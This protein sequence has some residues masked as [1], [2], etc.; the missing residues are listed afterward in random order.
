[1][2]GRRLWTAICVLIIVGM[3][4]EVLM[5]TSM[6]FQFD[7]SWM[8][9]RTSMMTLMLCGMLLC[10]VLFAS[11]YF[12]KNISKNNFFFMCM[13][14]LEYLL[15]LNEF[16][17]M[18]TLEAHP[19]YDIAEL[20]YLL[21]NMILPLMVWVF[22]HFEMSL[23][24]DGKYRGYSMVL[25]ILLVVMIGINLIQ[26]YNGG[27]FEVVDGR[28]VAKDL[29]IYH[30]SVALLMGIVCMVFAAVYAPGFRKKVVLVSYIALPLIML[31]ILLPTYVPSMMYLT[32]LFVLVIVYGSIYIDRG[33]TIAHNKS[34]ITDRKISLILARIEPHFLS[35]A[36]DDISNI[37][38]N[39]E[40]TRNALIKF[41]TYLEEN[42]GTMSQMAP[43][44]FEKELE[45]VKIYTDLEKLRF[46]DNVNVVFDIRVSSFL[47]PSMTVQMM[48]ENAI[49]HGITQKE[50]GGTVTVRTSHQGKDI[51]ITVADDGVGFDV[52]APRD[53]SR[54]H[55][56]L[57]NLEA[58]IKDMGG[59]FKITSTPGKGTVAMIFLPTDDNYL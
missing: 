36:L 11:V 32:N 51:V 14:S 15:L 38:G 13:I 42:I 21:G 24:G 19:E 23:L 3:V 54:S 50:N 31:A 41:K 47:I 56:G 4:F 28:Y 55:I 8:A 40:E 35:E 12:D 27:I 39:P 46:K 16:I 18:Y 49:K 5:C 1:M 22:G 26:V 57:D 17:R 2:I 59:T 10:T 53:P 9:S 44:K 43:I 37:E 30:T 20:S 33:M 29:D 52:N 7:P 6:L 58:R 48:V 34:L 25:N 45:H